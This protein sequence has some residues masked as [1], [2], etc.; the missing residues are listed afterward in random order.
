MITAG[1]YKAKLVGAYVGESKEK[2]TPY[3]GLEFELLDGQESIDYTAYLTDATKERAIKTLVDL[4]FKLNH[5]HDI[6][7]TSIAMTDMFDTKEDINLV[8][9][10]E[11]Y[12]DKDGNDKEKARVKFVNVGYKN[13]V[14][15]FNKT[16]AVRTFKTM[17]LDGDL[18]RIRRGEYKAPEAN[19]KDTTAKAETENTDY[20]SENIPF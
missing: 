15:K 3:Y 4:G 8:I 1:T 16:Q 10:M 18:A 12:Q 13:T 9:E 6:A 11:S 7:D 5:I 14:T 20:A 17:S 19:K 2:K